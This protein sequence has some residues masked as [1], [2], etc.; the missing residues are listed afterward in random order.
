ML[1]HLRAILS[2]YAPIHGQ[3]AGP[4]DLVEI[5]NEHRS[6]P[7]S[8]ITHAVVLPD[9]EGAVLMWCHVYP[10]NFDPNAHGGQ[11][12]PT[13]TFLWKPG[14]PQRVTKF[15]VPNNVNGSEDLFCGGHQFLPDGDV[16]SFG[17]TD[18]T[19]TSHIFGHAAA[20]RFD[21]ATQ[22]WSSAGTMHRERWYPNGFLTPSGVVV[23]IGH[24]ENPV[25]ALPELT[26][27]R[28]QDRF[29]ATT[30]AWASSATVSEPSLR[31]ARLSSTAGIPCGVPDNVVEIHDYPRRHLLARARQLRYMDL[32]T[33]Q[34]DWHLSFTTSCTTLPADRWILQA[35]GLN[36]QHA[37]G[38]TG[39]VVVLGP[40]TDLTFPR[41]YGFV[42]AGQERTTTYAAQ[43]DV[44]M[45]S[46][47]GTAAVWDPTFPDL[48]QGRINQ[49]LVI[50]ADGS[51]LVVGGSDVDPMSGVEGVARLNPER[52]VSSNFP[53]P[54]T[55]D[56]WLAMAP[57]THERRYHSVAG[58]LPD[59]RVFSAGGANGDLQ[60]PA[61]EPWHHSIEIYSP[62]YLF[63]GPRPVISG[64]TATTWPISQVP[65][66]PNPSFSVQLRPGST[67]DRVAL[68]RTGSITHAFD[69]S[70]RYVV[71]NT[72]VFPDPAT[73]D[74]YT[75][76]VTLPPTLFATPAG[77][78]ML[79]ALSSL[80]VPSVASMIRI[81]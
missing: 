53:L 78:Y 81:N 9:P 34:Q 67:L 28:M 43:T 10:A 6:V 55:G 2:Y 68:V 47:V 8:E 13:H 74:K 75:V 46:D 7:L 32:E 49:N 65:L 33:S 37:E 66:P 50:L 59:G 64:L 45:W 77:D 24:T 60:P 54:G 42:A 18:M 1:K 26:T 16:L 72:A 56:A 76:I 52:F 21:L 73:P 79:F 80:G 61:P 4:Y 14:D 27:Q 3:W 71:L 5:T 48:I 62:P 20:F 58:L 30:G 44:D 35:G 63:N 12:G 22:S 36:I 19:S 51:L 69:S 70:Q 17:G 29:S 11:P 40:S 39:H 57:Q 23:T 25:Y 41:D 31:N 38:S 15:D